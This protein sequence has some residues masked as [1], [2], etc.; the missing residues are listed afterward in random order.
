VPGGATKDRASQKKGLVFYVRI[1]VV[2]WLCVEPFPSSAV[3]SLSAHANSV[4]Y[5]EYSVDGRTVH[6]IVRLPLDDVD[7]LLRLDRDLDGQVSNAELDASRNAIRAYLAKHL[8]VTMNRATIAAAL[9]RAGAWRDPSGFQ[10]LEGELTFRAPQQVARLS[11]RS[12]LLTDLY[13][14]HKTLGH[15]SAGGREER[16]TFHSAATYERQLGP[17]RMTIVA[18]IAGVALLGLLLFARRR[19]AAAAVA[20]VLVAAPA[21]ADVIMSAPALN[22]TLKTMERLKRQT[23]TD[24]KP[25]RDTAWFQLGSEADGLA[26]LMNLEVDA[27]GMQEREL[28]DL[29]L[30]RTRELGVG[31]AYN[32]EKKKFFYDG[33]AFA[34]YLMGAP[35]GAHAAMAEFKLLSYSFYQLSAHDTTALVAAADATKSFLARYRK[36]EASAEVRL[37]LAVD[38][39]DLHRRALEAQDATMAARWRQH[40]RAE[41]RRITA[42]YPRTEQADA[43]RQLLRTLEVR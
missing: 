8:H 34:T 20:L 29:A 42:L 37:Y 31:I 19:A 13:P 16:F 1:S 23:V 22:S 18:S 32:R 36:F 28:L 15:I 21:H 5:A 2:L 3:L 26:S 11:I 33:A 24:G 27:H 40:A 35:R 4:S 25:G 12:D 10:Y 30:R 14:S 17:D 9:D 39:R 7:L 38:Y 41:C 6:A 43:A